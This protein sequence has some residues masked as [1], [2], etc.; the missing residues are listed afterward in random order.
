MYQKKRIIESKYF[1]FTFLLLIL[2]YLVLKFWDLQIVKGNNFFVYSQNLNKINFL[3]NTPLRGDFFDYNGVRLTSNLSFYDVYF[4]Y[5]KS[6]NF[7]NIYSEEEQKKYLLIIASISN[8]DINNVY[9]ILQDTL[10]LQRNLLINTISQYEFINAY[11]NFD[12]S[13]LPINIKESYLRNYIYPKE[14][15]HIIGYVGKVD[16]YTLDND[17]FY[18]SNDYHGKYKLEKDLEDFLRGKKVFNSDSYTTNQL[19]PGSSVYLNIYND[20]QIML[21]KILEKEINRY[22]AASGSSIIMETNTG[23]IRAMVS[24][25]GLDSNKLVFGL[26]EEEYNSLLNKRSLPFLDKSIGM[27]AHPGSTFKLVTSY[28][29]LENKKIDLTYKVYSNRCMNISNSQIFCE[30]NRLFYGDMNIIKAIYKSSNIFFCDTMLKQN[31]LNDLISA[32]HIFNLG[33]LTN[34][35][36]S[37]E[38]KGFLDLPNTRNKTNNSYWYDGDTCNVSIGQGGMLTTPIQMLMVISSIYNKG[39]YYKPYVVDKIVDF[40]NNIIIK[41]EPVILKEIKMENSYEILL[42]ALKQSVSNPDAWMYNLSF[43][44]NNV[45]GKTGTAETFENINGVFHPR[46]HGWVIGTFDYNNVNYSFV[47]HINNGI[48]GSNATYVISEFLKCLNNNFVNCN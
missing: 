42:D 29:L 43:L 38:T 27:A 10:K 19:L 25:E 40:N 17:K 33:N 12:F 1:Y 2:I 6:L 24:Y 15:S 31:G 46:T 48:K 5:F 22:V 35:D 44:P 13:D 7:T 18:S 41:K 14:Y 9:D 8:L 47:V 21:Y 39:L 3:R 11:K 30:Y 26:N 32:T 23:K 36:I 16:L 28:A 37:G 4:D 45:L 34:I 20:W